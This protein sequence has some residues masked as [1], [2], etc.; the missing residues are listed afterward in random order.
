[1]IYLS[2][3]GHSL[4]GIYARCVAGL[5]LRKGLIPSKVIPLNFITLATPHL[6]SREHSKILGNRFTSLLV[7]SVVG[8]TGKG[9]L[10]LQRVNVI[11]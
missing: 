8:Q 11:R 10:P 7:G 5:L 1:V 9:K 6:G 4:G 2:L 3:I